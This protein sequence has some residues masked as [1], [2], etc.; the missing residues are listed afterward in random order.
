MD[1]TRPATL[2]ALLEH[3]AA[4]RKVGIKGGLIP[5]ELLEPQSWDFS[6]PTLVKANGSAYRERKLCTSATT[7]AEEFYKKHEFLRGVPLNGMLVAGSSVGAIVDTDGGWYPND[8]DLFLYGH[9]STAA[10][11]ARIERF[12]S[13]LDRAVRAKGARKTL[14]QLDARIKEVSETKSR[15]ADADLACLKELSTAIRES[16]LA[17]FWRRGNKMVLKSPPLYDETNWA[18]V[19]KLA[20]PGQKHPGSFEL[21][22]VQIVRTSGSI[23]I[24]VDHSHEMQIVLRHYATASE[25]LHGFDLGSAAVGF[26]GVN[27]WLTALGRFAYECGYN[28][29]DT[30]R[31]SLTYESRIMKYFHRGFELILPGLDVGQLPRR[32]LKYDYKEV[33]DL[34][35]LV[36]GY[37]AI[38]GNRIHHYEFIRKVLPESDYDVDDGY[39]GFA[40][41]YLNL[42]RLVNGDKNF[43]FT[44]KGRGFLT[45]TDVLTKPPHLTIDMI[46]RAYDEFRK[47]CWDGARLN[48][49][50][51]ERYLPTA[52]LAELS[53]IVFEGASAD[54]TDKKMQAQLTAAFAIQRAEAVRLWQ[55]RIRDANHTALPWVTE[56]PGGQAGPLTGSLNPIFEDPRAWYG[57]KYYAR[58]QDS[59]FVA[60][61]PTG[62]PRPNAPGAAA[63]EPL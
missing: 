63:P 8:V 62:V 46:H 19:M 25:I 27:V 60:G 10:A 40:V 17:C 30:S 5:L 59:V 31:R 38:D 36:F 29:V 28:V 4:H 11:E 61:L 20:F 54:S 58:P 21:P 24:L 37:A 33:A 3:D 15:T 9:E 50:T 53:R 13:D 26:D 22:H 55:E 47:A 2:A 34:P 41:A 7:F 56:N 44:A 1:Y 45:A 23:S 35:R 32:N 42:W 49:R 6:A 48:V 18:D 14:E 51:I 57:D 16:L 12:I 52:S 39:D 43:V